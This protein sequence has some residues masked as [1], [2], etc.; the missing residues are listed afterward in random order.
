MKRK[1][2]IL[3]AAVIVLA[4]LLCWAGIGPYSSAS[5]VQDLKAQLEQLY[6][7]EYTGKPTPD[8]TEDMAFV[9]QPQTW[10]FTNWNLRNALQMDYKYVCK[11]VFTTHIAGSPT[12]TR[13][14]TYQAIDPMGDAA[15][16]TRAHL[17]H[18]SETI[19]P[20]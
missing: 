15:M 6:G 11:V 14:I 1:I 10:F 7:Q 8:G 19:E 16:G 17:I 13:T 3:L 12:R 9:V 4:V 5:A 18:G 20:G 2:V